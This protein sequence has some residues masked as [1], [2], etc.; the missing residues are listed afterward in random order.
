M[1]LKLQ[2]PL[3][4][5]KLHQLELLRSTIK[6]IG[7]VCVAY[8]GGVDSS[9][10]AAISQEQLGENAIAITGVSDSLAPYLRKEAKQQAH[11]I[12]IRH[13]ECLTKELEN[14]NYSQNPSDRCFACKQE[15]HK[16]LAKIADHFPNAQVI[17]GVNFDDLSD[18][19]PGIDAARIA[20]VRSPLAEN[21]IQKSTIRAISKAL[22]FPWWDKPSQPCLAS[23][24]PY[25][26]SITSLRL[27]Q[28]ALAEK[29]LIDN[30]FPE[31]RVRIQGFGAKLELPVDRIHDLLTTIQREEIVDFFLSIGF[32]SISV[33]LEGLISGKLN[34]EKEK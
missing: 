4:E 34:R 3:S 2:E 22:G 1:V 21:K 32:S 19:R 15:L 26:E 31:V 24:F 9:L 29:W 25:G 17:D 27:N 5:A 6:K 18:H 14:P 28:V 13:Q 11:W 20:G 33:D 12:G 8:S 23:R 7:K 16:H 30:G 10:I